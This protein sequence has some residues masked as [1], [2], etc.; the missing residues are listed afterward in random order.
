MNTSIARYLYRDTILTFSALY[1]HASPFLNLLADPFIIC[2]I[3]HNS[4]HTK[5]SEP[6][7]LLEQTFPEI[8]RKSIQKQYRLTQHSPSTKTVSKTPNHHIQQLQ[9]PHITFLSYQQTSAIHQSDQAY[10]TSHRIISLKSTKKQYTFF[11]A[12]PFFNH[13][14]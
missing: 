8:P 5:L 9:H 7:N 13:T 6:I 11:T 1:T 12:S 4:H 14:K 2:Q 10:I 3:Y